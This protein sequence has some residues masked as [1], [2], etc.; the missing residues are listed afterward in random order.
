MAR[1]STKPK[2]DIEVVESVE[3]VESKIEEVVEETNEIEEPIVEAVEETSIEEPQPEKPKRKSTKKTVEI[4]AEEVVEEPKVESKIEEVVETSPKTLVVRDLTIL[5]RDPNLSYPLA[6]VHGVAELIE[7]CDVNTLYI[8]ARVN[9]N[10]VAGYI[11]R[12]DIK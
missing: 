9:S 10:V 4:V 12:G 5:Y 6:R 7:V 8:R 1:R 3:T 2:E 11:N